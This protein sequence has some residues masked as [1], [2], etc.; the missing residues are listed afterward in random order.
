MDEFFP[1]LKEQG[2]HW[3]TK[4]PVGGLFLFDALFLWGHPKLF[5]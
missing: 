1:A 3:E 5:S 2:L 4:I